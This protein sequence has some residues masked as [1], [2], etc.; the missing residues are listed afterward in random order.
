MTY[1]DELASEIERQVPAE[2]LPG[3][4]TRPL[5]RL[6]ALL[7]LAKGRS[8]SEADVHNAWATWMSERDPDHR[9]LKPYEEL[10]AETQAS[11]VPF[12]KAIREVAQQLE[13]TP[14]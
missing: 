1:L 4:D 12:A 6:Y 11:D 9:S 5:F 10:D 8:V 14:A 13:Q 7:A 3:G 2:V